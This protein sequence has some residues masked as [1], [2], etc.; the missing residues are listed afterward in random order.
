MSEHPNIYIKT[1][2]MSLLQTIQ[3]LPWSVLH[4]WWY[5][6]VFLASILE[7]FPIFGTFIPGHTIVI[8]W[9]FL[10]KLGI[11]DLWDILIISALWAILGDFIGYFIG[12]RYGHNFIVKYWKYVFFKEAYFEKTKQLITRH[13]GKTII[14][15]RF[16][17][18]IRALV[19]FVAG[20]LEIHLPKFS[21]YNVIGGI[22]WATSSVL[23]GFVFGQSY[24]IVA[25]YIGR[26]VSVALIVSI[27][28]VFL[29]RFVNERRHI[30]LKYRPYLLI[31]N[32]GSLYLFAKM[33]EDVLDGE[34]ITKWD[35]WVHL[36]IVSFWN[37]LLNRAMILVSDMGSPAVLGILSVF[38]C[39]FFAHKK[40]W[41]D[42][43]LTSFVMIG[44]WILEYTVKILT[45]RPRPDNVLIP[46]P[47]DY[48][49]PSAH[50]TIAVIFFSLLIYLF[51]DTIRNKAMKVTFIASCI[52]WF[53][54]VGF[55]RIYLNVH[56]LSDVLAGIGLGM[57]WL[58]FTILMVKIAK[59]FLRKKK[60]SKW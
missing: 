52:V 31:L 49:F 14:I 44:G 35:M 21:L 39:A 55:S 10:A 17:P 43:W 2:I 15:G 41:Q 3:N 24:E 20:S 29:Y 23:I 5:W 13:A 8:L 53:L 19:P 42:F 9:G 7:A 50:S 11:L 16:N 57:F 22:S 28:L 6:I 26:F 25:K 48:S 40:R 56:Y 59:S 4:Q 30:F 33:M 18:V 32:I 60:E 38:L 34:L 36:H 46:L 27:I 51:K 54:I 58:T 1:K 12:K 47:M 37:P 45:Q